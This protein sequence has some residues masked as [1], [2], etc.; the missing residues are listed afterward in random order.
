MSARR[1]FTFYYMLAFASLPLLSVLAPRVM[2]FGP[3]LIGLAGCIYM[4]R[5]GREGGRNFNRPYFYVAACIGFLACL[6][7]LWADYPSDVLEKGVLTGL[8]VLCGA[9]P[10]YAAEHMDIER[11]RACSRL[12][13]ALLFSAAVMAAAELALGL[14]IY[15]LLHGVE[16]GQ[17]IYTSVIN[18][19]AVNIV[20]SLFCAL[21]LL[22]SVRLSVGLIL[23]VIVMLAL[24]QAQV[25]Q[26][27]LVCG[28]AAYALYPA[29]KKPGLMSLLLGGAVCALLIAAPW[30]AQGMFASLA[31]GAREISWLREGYAASRMEIWDFTSRY[32]LERPLTGHG[33]DATRYVEAFEHA[34]LYHREDGVLHPHNFAIQIWVDFGI[35]GVFPACALLWFLFRKAAGIEGTAGRAAMATLLSTIAV[36]GISYG[37]WQSH[38]LGVMIYLL[39][40]VRMT[41]RI[42]RPQN[43]SGE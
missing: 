19:G 43:I 10:L 34:H 25:A 42:L 15:K 4:M 12:I 23:T 3:G 29:G 14:P 20:L 38:W 1:D 11:L 8:L 28:L 35:L 5:T 2:A 26:L 37:L 33:L 16:D 27:I 24:S 32:A 22:N 17:R 36:A 18:R 31:E 30:I 7:A 40:L 9:F 41:Q 21:A 13:P 6:S 39:A